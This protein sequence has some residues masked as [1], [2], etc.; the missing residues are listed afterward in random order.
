MIFIDSLWIFIDLLLIFINFHYFLLDAGDV[1][2]KTRTGQSVACKSKRDLNTRGSE[3]S[4]QPGV[5]EVVQACHD[6]A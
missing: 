6:K 1:A 3:I 4:K 2:T 5:E